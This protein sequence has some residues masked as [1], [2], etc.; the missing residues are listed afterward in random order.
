MA[1]NLFTMQL[2]HEEEQL[3]TTASKLTDRSKSDLVRSIVV[4]ALENLVAD[5]G[6]CHENFRTEQGS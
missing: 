6:S 5:Q 3:L 2:L 4:P 1:S